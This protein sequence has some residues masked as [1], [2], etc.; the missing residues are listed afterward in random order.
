M[1]KELVVICLHFFLANS[2]LFSQ[3]DYI[4]VLQ[5][6]K[7]IEEIKDLRYLDSVPAP[8]LYID[9]ELVI[10]YTDSEYNLIVFFETWC[11]P[12]LKEI[13]FILNLLKYE[14]LKIYIVSLSEPEEVRRYFNNS[15]KLH[16]FF[17][18]HAKELNMNFI[19]SGYPRNY[20]INNRGI[21][22][23]RFRGFRDDNDE[24]YCRII[25]FIK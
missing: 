18:R 10:D 8:I 3:S 24:A 6:S 13:P 1:G 21:I 23:G 14:K 4:R 19:E 20:L 12:C 9:N 16:F 15:E 7:T 17:H 11:S 25:S 2:V 5:K 22:C